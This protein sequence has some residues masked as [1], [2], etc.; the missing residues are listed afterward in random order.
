MQLIFIFA[1]AVIS[2]AIGTISIKYG[3]SRI[4]G[5]NLLTSSGIW[6][7]FSNLYIMGGL[8]LYGAGFPLYTFLLQKLNVSIAYPMFT[9]LSFAAVILIAAI[10]LKEGLTFL[11]ICGLILVIGG[12]VLLATS[13]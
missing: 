8:A 4:A 5:I 6:S 1:L 10:F 13:K 2:N 3:T 11:Q 7:I 12:I 9:S